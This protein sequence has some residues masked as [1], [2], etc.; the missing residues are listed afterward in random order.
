VGA[1][2]LGLL[3][4]CPKLKIRFGSSFLTGQDELAKSFFVLSGKFMDPR[5]CFITE[6]SDKKFH[7]NHFSI[8]G[9]RAMSLVLV[10]DFCK[11]FSCPGTPMGV[12]LVIIY[13]YVCFLSSFWIPSLTLFT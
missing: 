13:D 12:I 5:A 3:K 9:F 2:A 11:I 8:M 6:A 10:E 7:A 1:E 4:L